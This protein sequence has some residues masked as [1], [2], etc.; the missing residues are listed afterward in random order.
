MFMSG[1]SSLLPG[2]FLLGGS[3]DGSDSTPYDDSTARNQWESDAQT[4]DWLNEQ[5]VIQSDAAA[6]QATLDA[7]NAAAASAAASA[8]VGIG[9]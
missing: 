8:A 6:N 5:S 7:T 9:Q 2:G 1:C 3:G 4:D